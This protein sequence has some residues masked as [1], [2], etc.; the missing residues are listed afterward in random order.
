MKLLDS[1]HYVGC[2][3][4][5]LWRVWAL[6]NGIVQVC[7]QQMHFIVQVSSTWETQKRIK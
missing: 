3:R 7:L 6:T 1:C 2:I 4:K 5:I